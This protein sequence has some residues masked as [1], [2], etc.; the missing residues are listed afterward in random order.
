MD[1]EMHSVRFTKKQVDLIKRLV[2]KVEY[3]RDILSTIEKAEA[4]M[5]EDKPAPG[6]EES[7]PL[8]WQ[9]YLI[10][11]ELKSADYDSDCNNRGR[12]DTNALYTAV[13]KLIDTVR[14]LNSSF[15]A[16]RT[17]Q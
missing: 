16:T 6:V 9:L 3:Q 7:D 15:R 5:A 1:R 8:G 11:K 2:T 12:H 17:K 13:Y 14:E 4:N 10:K